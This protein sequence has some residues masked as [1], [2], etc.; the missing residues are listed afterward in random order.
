MLFHAVSSKPEGTATRHTHG[1]THTEL[2]PFMLRDTNT[3]VLKFTIRNFEYS[4][5][6]KQT[7]T[8]TR[9]HR[10]THRHRSYCQCSSHV[11][12]FVVSLPTL[13]VDASGAI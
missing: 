6:V 13:E 7:H 8:H 11:E 9:T 4:S 1:H 12:I 3:V 5:T 10:H 2:F